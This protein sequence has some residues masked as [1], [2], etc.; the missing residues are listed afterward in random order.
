MRGKSGRGLPQS[1]TLARDSV[2]PIHVV[3]LFCLCT[4]GGFW[5]D[6]NMAQAMADKVRQFAP[7]LF[8]G[9]ECD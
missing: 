8:H 9:R 4:E 6:S 5:K 2:A 7:K 3:N 1:K